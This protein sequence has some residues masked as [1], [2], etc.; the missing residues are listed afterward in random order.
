MSVTAMLTMMSLC[1]ALGQLWYNYG[2]M[3]MFEFPIFATRFLR[4][5][6]TSG[7]TVGLSIVCRPRLP[8]F[9]SIE[10]Y[11]AVPLVALQHDCFSFPG[12][13]IH[14][15]YF[16]SVGSRHFNI[17]SKRREYKVDDCAKKAA[18]PVRQILTQDSQSLLQ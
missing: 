2:I 9:C 14:T 10:P 13:I 3:K 15:P 4:L 11:N 1:D 8:G 18:W 16:L 5:N 6:V 7:P 12:L 17:F